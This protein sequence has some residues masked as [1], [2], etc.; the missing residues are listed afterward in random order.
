MPR[1]FANVWRQPREDELIPPD[2]EAPTN[3]VWVEGRVLVSGWEEDKRA[4]VDKLRIVTEALCLTMFENHDNGQYNSTRRRWT[5]RRVDLNG[6]MTS[7]QQRPGI[8]LTELLE[9]TYYVPGEPWPKDLAEASLRKLRVAVYRLVHEYRCVKRYDKQ[10]R[11]RLF[12][13]GV[14]EANIYSENISGK[15]SQL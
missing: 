4:L 12:V 15:G 14:M 6:I 2:T 7:I 3:W 8:L 10:G 5:S 1:K 11:M 9:E 13:S